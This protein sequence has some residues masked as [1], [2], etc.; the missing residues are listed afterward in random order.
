MAKGCE[1]LSPRSR[2]LVDPLLH[3]GDI[4]HIVLPD[5]MAE[6]VGQEAGHFTRDQEPLVHLH[7]EV[8]DLGQQGRVLGLVEGEQGVA[9]SRMKAS[10]TSKCSRV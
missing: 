4:V 1:G 6:H 2:E 5:V 7:Q 8:L 3:E 10:S 9:T